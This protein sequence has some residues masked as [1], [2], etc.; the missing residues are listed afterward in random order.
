MTNYKIFL[1]QIYYFKQSDKTKI[2]PSTGRMSAIGIAQWILHEN[3][4]I[5]F[6]PESNGAI[7]KI[8]EALE[9][10]TNFSDNF[11]ARRRSR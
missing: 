2:S 3:F 9:V 1:S 7:I 11:L 8:L 10:E 6:F 4:S 5:L